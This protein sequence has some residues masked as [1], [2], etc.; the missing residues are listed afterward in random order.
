MDPY[1]GAARPYYKNY[2]LHYNARIIIL[3]L[4]KYYKYTRN[5]YLKI[6]SDNISKVSSMLKD[7]VACYGT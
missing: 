5:L 1:F 3:P 2:A 6:L 7:I 4:S